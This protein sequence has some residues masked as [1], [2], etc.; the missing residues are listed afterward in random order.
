MASRFSDGRA[1]ALGGW[2]VA[3][4]GWGVALHR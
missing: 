4:S 2:G 3:L 1:V